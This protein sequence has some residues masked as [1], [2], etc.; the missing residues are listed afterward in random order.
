MNIERSVSLSEVQQ[1]REDQGPW[2]CLEGYAGGKAEKLAVSVARDGLHWPGATH[3]ILTRFNRPKHLLPDPVLQGLQIL[4]C[5][6]QQARLERSWLHGAKESGKGRLGIGWG[7]AGMPDRVYYKQDCFPCLI[8]K[9]RGHL[10]Q[11]K[12]GLSKKSTGLPQSF[13][14]QQEGS[15]L[16]NWET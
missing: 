6:H 10:S 16:N 8:P 7:R 4:A 2:A 9:L 1:S 14:I 15:I 5:I 12:P 3:C 11:D 13:R